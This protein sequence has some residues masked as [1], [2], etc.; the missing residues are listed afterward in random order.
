LFNLVSEHVC[1]R[2]EALD[3]LSSHEMQEAKIVAPAAWRTRSM[4]K[5]G[6]GWL[7]VTS[8]STELL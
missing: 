5:D 6:N 4:K 3:S 8:R 7:S 1:S 2:V